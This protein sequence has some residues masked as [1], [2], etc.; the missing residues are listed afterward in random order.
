MRRVQIL[1]VAC[2]VVS[3]CPL[4]AARAA[5]HSSRAN[6]VLASRIV[7]FDNHG[8]PL[9]PTFLMIG[10]TYSIPVGIERVVP[11]ARSRPITVRLDEGTLKQLLDMAA[12]SLPGY[13]WSLEDGVI[14]LYG[15]DERSRSTNLLNTVVH[16]FEL[17]KGTIN[18]ANAKLREVIFTASAVA[19]NSNLGGPLGIGGDS[20]GVGSLELMQF[21]FTMRNATV[22][23]ILNRLVRLSLGVPGGGVAWVATVPPPGLD[24]APQ[25]GLWEL[26]PLG[27]A[28]S[29]GAER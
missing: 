7:H 1:L 29:A 10:A 27:A 21:T 15:P 28:G 14:D 18:D 23:D 3:A 11:D 26:V 9:V 16:E 22:R 8:A 4:S 2:A 19:A 5:S 17:N 13:A 24:R 20:P 6:D 12:G 25:N